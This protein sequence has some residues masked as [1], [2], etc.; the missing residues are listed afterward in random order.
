MV[1]NKVNDF[2]LGA[3]ESCSRFKNKVF[4][5]P[6]IFRSTTYCSFFFSR[7]EIGFT[8]IAI[9]NN[10]IKRVFLIHHVFNMTLLFVCLQFMTLILLRY[11]M[12]GSRSAENYR[13][14]FSK[15]IIS[16]T[17]FSILLFRSFSRFSPDIVL[18][19]FPGKLFIYCILYYIVKNKMQRGSLRILCNY[20][21]TISKLF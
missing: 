2:P 13:W 10:Q 17:L 5:H 7:P 1:I 15:H 14:S 20:W 4:Q 9:I 12:R 21:Y 6:I 3:F 18:T 16:C 19:K 8:K 11:S